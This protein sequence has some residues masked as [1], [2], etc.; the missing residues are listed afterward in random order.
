MA[1]VRKRY[2]VLKE[3]PNYPNG[4]LPGDIIEE[5]EDVGTVLMSAGVE[6]VELV[7]DDT[8]LG[9]P[10]VRGTYKRRDLVAEKRG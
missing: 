3:L 6:A 1:F 9:R 7:A 10:S 8:P 2:R 5:N 4:Y